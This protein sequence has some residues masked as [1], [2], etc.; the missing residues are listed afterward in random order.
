MYTN[1]ILINLIFTNMRT[2]QTISLVKN[3][4]KMYNIYNFL[5]IYLIIISNFDS[6][7]FLGPDPGL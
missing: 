1:I 5:I 4:F 6:F 2:I 7:D 3:N